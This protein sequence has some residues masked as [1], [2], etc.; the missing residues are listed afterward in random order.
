MRR[1][2]PAGAIAVA[3]ISCSGIACSGRDHPAQGH[4]DAPAPR[5]S[6]YDWVRR[7]DTL[8]G[9]YTAVGQVVDVADSMVLLTDVGDRQVWRIDLQRRSRTPFGSRGDGPGEYRQTG[10]MLRINI[11]SVMLLQGAS[12]RPFPVLAIATGQGRTR[13]LDA[14]SSAG[15]PGGRLPVVRPLIRSVDCAGSLYGAPPTVQLARSRDGGLVARG[16]E[17]I[18]VVRISPDGRTVD[19]LV[20][21]PTGEVP[22]EA[23]RNAAGRVTLWADPG[24]YAAPNG[25]TALPD[26]RV[27]V[28]DASR[29]ALTLVGER[30][31]V[32]R[33]WTVSYSPV[34]VSTAGWEA[35]LDR[36]ARRQQLVLER[37]SRDPRVPV[38]LSTSAGSLLAPDMPATLPPVAMEGDV[39]RVLHATDSL[40]FVPV[41]VADPPLDEH[42]DI[43]DLAHGRRLATVSLPSRHR[44]LHVG[45]TGAFIAWRDADD[46]ERVLRVKLPFDSVSVCGGR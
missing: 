10:A 11:D 18:P 44:L 15:T 6:L 1:I 21:V 41:N 4:S 29:Y 33:R 46:I 16:V 36:A 30:G 25:W 8:P 2:R 43:L 28:V 14:M 37:A 39:S 12:N 32:Q 3:A 17:A 22:R 13:Q 9:E 34:R 45:S 38:P 20:R 31:R 27:V 23:S 24:P 26:G 42:W 40:L 19:T 35:H 7:I 5:L